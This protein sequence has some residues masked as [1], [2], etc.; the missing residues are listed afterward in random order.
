MKRN[1]LLGII[2]SGSSLSAFAQSS[3]IQKPITITPNVSIQNFDW[4]ERSTVGKVGVQLQFKPTKKL[5]VSVDGSLFNSL[6]NATNFNNAVSAIS[7]ADNSI[8]NGATYVPTG[9]SGAGSS[10]MPRT[11]YQGAFVNIDAGIPIKLGDSSRT[12]I[13]PFVGVEG[14]IWSRSADYGTEGNPLIYEEKYKFLSPSLGAKLSYN[15]KSKVKLSLRISAS[16]PVISKLKT[17]SKNLANPN[18]EID[19]TKWLSP[20]VELGARI[21]KVTL[22]LRYER[23]NIGTADT[24][25]GCSPASRAD[26]T[27]LSIGYDF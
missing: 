25:R 18:A 23:I 27:G 2:L 21:K 19:L 12:T 24:I 15:T 22:K 13:E 5:N 16:Y 4:L 9:I 6:G 20:S 11:S 1:V 17:D 8:K 26:V 3:D 7:T 10:G 14:K